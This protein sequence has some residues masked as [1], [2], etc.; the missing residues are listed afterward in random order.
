MIKLKSKSITEIRLKRQ[1]LINIGK[2]EDYEQLFRYMSPVPTLFWTT[3]GEPPVIPY[4][5]AEDDRSLNQF[6][7]ARR[8]IIKG[9]F[10]GGSVGYIYA[11]EL[12]L[13]MA[14]YKKDIKRFNENDEL[15]LQTLRSEG[16]MS[17]EIM[18][19]IT[20]LLSKQIAASLQK[21]QKSFIVFEDQV[22]NEWDRAWYILEDE[23]FDRD[24]NRFSR[25][26]AM[27]EVIRRFAF[28]N[29]FFDESMVKSFTR[30]TVKDI[31]KTLMGM[32]EKGMLKEAEAAGCQGYILSED[33]ENISRCSGEIP[34]KTYI[35]DLND[36]LVRSNE[37]E[38]KKRF[39]PS[40]Y[41]TLHY[42][43]KQGEFIGIVAGRF[44]FGPNEL[45]NV[46][47]DQPFIDKGQSRKDIIQ[48]IEKVYNPEETSLRRYCGKM[49]TNR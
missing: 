44:C 24:L 47:L 22:D 15:V 11:D 2:P 1:N 13:F 36:Y 4:R 42:I 40:P 37:A 9:R 10:R 46:I 38:L 29:V 32:L 23:F 26:E 43:L 25:E 14:A 28:L 27:E 16:A 6:N 5:T 17:I 18:K 7:R 39:N 21:M 8:T 33:E 35:L 30:F 20:G 48:A 12:P 41:K 49:I 3:P 19:E 34:D 31:K 45:E